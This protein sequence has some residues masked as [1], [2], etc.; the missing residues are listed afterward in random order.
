MGKLLSLRHW[1]S[2]LL[3]IFQVMK[4]KE[5]ALLDKL[6]FTIPVLLYWIL[7][8]ILPGLPV[9]DIAVTMALA[10]WFA[11]RMRRKYQFLNK[12]TD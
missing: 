5:V 12:K 11:Q 1:K 4:S 10:E 2:T 8:D 3:L 7:P 6:I 9:D